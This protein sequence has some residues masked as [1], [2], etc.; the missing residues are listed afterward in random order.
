MNNHKV[1]RKVKEAKFQ[2]IDAVLSASGCSKSREMVN[3]EPDWSLADTHKNCHLTFCSFNLI[4]DYCPFF[5]KPTHFFLPLHRPL[6]SWVTTLLFSSSCHGMP[7]IAVVC[8]P[9]LICY[10]FLHV[11]CTFSLMHGIFF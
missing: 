8:T 5:H 1:W 10:T 7:F 4:T 3:S 2:R 9:K 11:S 6:H